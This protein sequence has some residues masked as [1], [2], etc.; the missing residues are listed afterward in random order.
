MIHETA[1]ID[2]SAVV[3][4]GVSIGPYAVIGPNCAI[5]EGTVIGSHVVIE[6]DCRLGKNNRI[7]SHAAV[8]GDPQDLKYG[9]E[10]TTCIIG[11]ENTVRE[12]VTIN[13]G[14]EEGG[15]K[16]VVGDGNLIMAYSHIAHDCI[17]GNSLILA[18]GLTL[19]GHV[20][21]HDCAVIGGLTGIHQFV[22]IGAHA[23]VGA[24][25]GVGRDIPPFVTAALTRGQKRSIFGI[26]RIG[27]KRRGF[28]KEKIDTIWKAVK[29]VNQIEFTVSKLIEIFETEFSDSEEVMY[30]AEFFKNSKRGVKRL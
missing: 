6:R 21:I 18:N 22:R 29:L 19:G 15:G 1:I 30:M 23:I 24:L 28:S 3:E 17:L 12:Y 9:G 25:S 20:E 5:G 7:Y 16:T 4:E 11:D 26:N 2:P 13:R 14:T 8:G 27:L 10:V